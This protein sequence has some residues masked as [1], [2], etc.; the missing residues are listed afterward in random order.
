[1]CHTAA[2]ALILAGQRE[3]LETLRRLL[4]ESDVDVQ[5]HV[6]RALANLSLYRRSYVCVMLSLL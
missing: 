6:A 1:M 4:L 3:L 5:R 2:S